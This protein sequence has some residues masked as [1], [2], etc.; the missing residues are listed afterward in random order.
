MLHHTR[1]LCRL[2]F[3]GLLCGAHVELPP[4]PRLAA[5][6]T[7]A[8]EQFTT[9]CSSTAPPP[10]ALAALTVVSLLMQKRLR[11]AAGVLS[12]HPQQPQVLHAVRNY[13][14]LYPD[15]FSLSMLREM[16]EEARCIS[17]GAVTT[18]LQA[19]AHRLL[20]EPP[21]GSAEQPDTDGEIQKK[22]SQRENLRSSLVRHVHFHPS[23][24]AAL[25]RPLCV[26][27]E[28]TA[29]E[30]E[31]VIEVMRVAMKQQ[32]INPADFGYVLEVLLRGGEPR[33][34]ALMWG[35]MQHTSACWDIRTTSA[36]IMAFAQLG[37]LDEAVACMQRL[38]EA[39]SNPSSEAQV[40][41]I[42]FL[43]ERTPPM[44]QYADQ[45]VCHWCPSKEL[46]WRGVGQEV[47]IELIKLHIRCGLHDQAVELLEAAYTTN[48]DAPAELH[49]FLQHPH[50]AVIGR[51][52]ASRSLE[53]TALQHLFLGTVLHSPDLMEG[54][55][56]MVG[57]LLC[58][59][60]SARRLP[61]VYAAVERLPLDAGAFQQALNF[62]ARGGA[63]KSTQ[64]EGVL[65]CMEEVALRTGNVVPTE[66]K[67]WLQLA[68]EM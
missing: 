4:P 5:A 40:A 52:Y 26:L 64:A 42:R 65:T 43:G 66:L 39:G 17:E 36:A 20:C 44:P 23:S 6:C 2:T 13:V 16:S 49:R 18:F 35:W 59:G 7:Q 27:S 22:V 21:P 29:A 67:V 19:A 68:K 62:F 3:E 34:V 15:V 50:V 53:R 33:R 47:G 55:P 25:L 54:R 60:M 41:F 24:A 57:L 37:R 51:R 32:M 61:E 31:N 30:R 48:A 28:G 9:Q 10:V 1:R 46:L 63:S 14:C 12:L 45:L 56:D 58:F 11:D 38:A 8:T